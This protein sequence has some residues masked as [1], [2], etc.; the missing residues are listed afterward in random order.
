MA[1]KAAESSNESAAV[2]WSELVFVCSKCMKRQDREDLRGDIKR[3]IKR[4][5]HR[6]LRIVACG[7]LDLCPKDGVTIARGRDLAIKP[8]VL[9]VIGADDRIDSVVDWLLDDR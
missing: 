3:A 4:A 9:R 6:E 1:K 2:G 7:C 5:G 8:P